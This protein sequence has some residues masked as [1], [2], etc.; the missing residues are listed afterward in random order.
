MN[1]ER[2]LQR[3]RLG[4]DSTLELKQVRLRAGGKTIEPHADG[5]SDEL[6]AL[7]NAHGGTLVLGVDDQTK[8]V[9]GIPLEH[10]DGVEAWLTAICTDR[11]RPPLEVVTHHLELPGPAGQPR[12]VI[13]AEVPRSLWVHESANGYFRRVGHAKRKLTPDV[14]ARLFQQRS[15]ARLIRFEEQEVPAIDFKDLDPLLVNRFMIDGQGDAALQLQRL[16]LVKE[17]DEG[18]RPTVAGVLLCTLDPQ[19]RL[20][21]AEIIAVAHAGLVNDPNEQ[22]DAQEIQGPLDRQIWDAIHFVRR[23]MRTP[24]RKPLGRI[25]Y[26]QY[27]LAAVFEAI[28]NAVAHRD[29]SRHAQR[30]RLFLFADRLE[31]YTPGALPN[32]MTIASMSAISAPRNE[33]IA[34]L[35]ARYYPVEEPL[36][37]KHQLMDRRGSGVRMILERSEAL[38]GRRPVYENL[39]DMELLLT[40]Y[41]AAGPANRMPGDEES[42]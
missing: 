9:S 22:V 4:E 2:L 30:I 18:P 35:F 27:D 8:E 37:G 17:S 21:N 1:I 26:P 33:V 12:A 38:S 11:I 31:I 15:Q 14:L 13:V 39:E 34:S 3:I 32:S 19:R 23:N 24:A 7:G 5:L 41:A 20:R 29:Y 10:L 25:D 36:F 40:I 42:G 6:A 16:H 28:V